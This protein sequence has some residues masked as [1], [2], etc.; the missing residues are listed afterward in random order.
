MEFTQVEALLNKL[1]KTDYVDIDNDSEIGIVIYQFGE[2][3][4]YKA[5]EADN[6]IA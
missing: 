1:V 6:I 2:L 4:S 5:L 3:A